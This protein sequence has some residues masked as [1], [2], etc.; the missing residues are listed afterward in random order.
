MTLQRSRAPSLGG[1]E[2]VCF[3]VLFLLGFTYRILARHYL[4][5]STSACSSWTVVCTGGGGGGGGGGASLLPQFACL[6]LH[7]NRLKD[8][9]RRYCIIIYVRWL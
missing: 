8:R 5:L 7:D 2:F 9:F 3:V 6:D 1:N 4:C